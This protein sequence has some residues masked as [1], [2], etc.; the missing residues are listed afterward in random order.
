[1]NDPESINVILSNF[2]DLRS[3]LLSW[4]IGNDD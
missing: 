1:M 3:S 4:G 2:H